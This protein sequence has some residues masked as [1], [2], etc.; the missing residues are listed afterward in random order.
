MLMPEV[1]LSLSLSHTHTHT[2]TSS[3]TV[4]V[5]LR[6]PC[7]LWSALGLK[8][9]LNISIQYR[10]A[11]LDGSTLMWFILGIQRLINGIAGIITWLVTSL[12]MK[13]E[14]VL[15]ILVYSPV[16]H[17]MCLL[18]HE[19]FI[20]F[21]PLIWHLKMGSCL[22][23]SQKV[24]HVFIDISWKLKIVKGSFFVCLNMMFCV[25][26]NVKFRYFWVK[27]KPS[28]M[29]KEVRSRLKCTRLCSTSWKVHD[30]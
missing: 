16:N 30:N 2:H 6:L 5:T 25:L 22:T 12:M 27:A 3:N 15:E 23:G 26:Q 28:Y 19:K 20:E 1:S 24:K 10:S 9:Q 17:L 29:D 13:T 4:W 14:I 21:F 11:Q 18:G 7:S 8:K